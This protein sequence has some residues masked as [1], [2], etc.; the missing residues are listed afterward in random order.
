M[1]SKKKCGGYSEDGCGSRGRRK[2]RGLMCSSGS[3]GSS[4]CG[5]LFMEKEKEK[6]EVGKKKELW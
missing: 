3:S 6:K 4:G 2:K 1:R 5:M